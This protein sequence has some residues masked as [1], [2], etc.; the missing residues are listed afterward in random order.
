M[1][2]LLLKIRNKTKQNYNFQNPASCNCSAYN[3]QYSVINELKVIENSGRLL[4][5][6]QFSHFVK[7]HQGLLF[8]AFQMQSA[9][10]GKILGQGFWESHANKRIKFTNGKY[11]SVGQFIV[12]VSILCI[13]HIFICA[14]FLHLFIN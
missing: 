7:T 12:A 2:S 1:H 10:R 3:I 11:L 9:L 13:L 14:L 5:L 4:N 8:P 6:D